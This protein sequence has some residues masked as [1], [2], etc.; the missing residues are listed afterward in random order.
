MPVARFRLAMLIGTLFPAV[1]LAQTSLTFP[2]RGKPVRLVI[3]EKLLLVRPTAKIKGVKKADEMGRNLAAN[4]IRAQAEILKVN[5]APYIEDLERNPPRFVPLAN[6][7]LVPKIRGLKPQQLFAL[8]GMVDGMQAA[9]PVFRY[10]LEPKHAVKGGERRNREASQ[11]VLQKGTL[12]AAFKEAPDANYLKTLEK[13][14]KIKVRRQAGYGPHVLQFV[15]LAGSE[16]PFALSEKL[17]NTGKVRWAQADL[18][19][20]LLPCGADPKPA[21]ATRIPNDGHFGR[22]WYLEPGPHR[23][24][25]PEAWSVSVG[26]V[27]IVVAVLDDGV[28]VDHPDLKENIVAGGRN[29]HADPPDGAVR[30]ADSQTHGTCCAGIIAARTDNKAGVAGLCWQGRILPI[31]ISGEDGFASIDGIAEAIV[32]ARK[33]GARILNCSWGGGFPHDAILEAIDTVTTEDKK[34][35]L[36]AALVIAAAGN[37]YPATDVFFPAYYDKCLAV[38]AIDRGNQRWYYSSFGPDHELDLVAP[39]GDVEWLGDLWTTD[40]SGKRGVNDGKHPK[41]PDKTGDFTARFGGTSAAAPVVAGVA[42]LV[43]STHPELTADQL[44]DCLLRSATMVDQEFGGWKNGRSKMYGFGRVDAQGA[45]LLAAK[46]AGGQAKKGNPEDKKEAESPPAGPDGTFSAFTGGGQDGKPM[47][48]RQL[49]SVLDP[50]PQV[51]STRDGKKMHLRPDTGYIAVHCAAGPPM[52]DPLFWNAVV[53]TKVDPERPGVK[54][55]TK[56]GKVVYLIHRGALQPMDKLVGEG[57]K[58]NLPVLT[59]VY[60]A[61]G[62]TLIPT[63]TI[64]LRAKNTDAVEAALA[65]L[66]KEKLRVVRQDGAVIVIEWNRESRF[67]CVFEAARDLGERPFAAW[68]QPNFFQQLRR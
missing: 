1:S 62:A 18:V 2:V 52:E 33:N 35:K 54:V 47:T 4:T 51:L 9:E 43:W 27:P 3:D 46:I 12:T 32:H 26:R 7:I 67:P 45:L 58:G 37:A 13:A 21:A 22:Q 68:A 29:F 31:R 55:G 28:D 10:D 64:T 41:E 38:G 42:A 15:R 11:L 23:I 40:H 14:L 63:G 20:Q 5:A 61:G 8:S 49:E 19:M 39:S 53:K 50:E 24:R 30:P 59:A 48:P 66:H 17:R 36:P 25:A 60:S 16:D 57:S 34:Q 56:D 65:W 44:R 6:G